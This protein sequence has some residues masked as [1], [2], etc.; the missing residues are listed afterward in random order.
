MNS[1]RRPCGRLY[2]RDIELRCPFSYPALELDGDGAQGG[3]RHRIGL[4]ICIEEADD[5]PPLLERLD[6]AIEQ[7]AVKTR[8][9]PMDAALAQLAF[10]GNHKAHAI[11][12]A[13]GSR[14]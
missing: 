6:Q 13:V 7:N 4:S 5:P 10:H 3:S 14:Q 9:V 12:G 8:I 1:L 11:A 2:D